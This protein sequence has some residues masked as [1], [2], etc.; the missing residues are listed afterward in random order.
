[1]LKLLETEFFDFPWCSQ[2]RSPAHQ[3]RPVIATSTHFGF[4]FHGAGKR[5]I[6]VTQKVCVL[7]KQ[8]EINYVEP[9]KKSVDDGP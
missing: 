7:L 3:A 9:A 2:R 5:R 8:S 6:E 4:I 1:M